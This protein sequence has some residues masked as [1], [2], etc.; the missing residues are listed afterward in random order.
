MGTDLHAYAYE[1]KGRK[2]TGLYLEEG[3]FAAMADNFEIQNGSGETTFSVNENGDLYGA[4]NAMFGGVVF[5]YKV[6]EKYLSESVNWE[7]ANVRIAFNKLRYEMNGSV[8]ILNGSDTDYNTGGAQTLLIPKPCEVINGLR[9][10]FV[11]PQAANV[12]IGC[13]G[14]TMSNGEVAESQHYSTEWLV[15]YDFKVN[16]STYSLDIGGL[17]YLSMVVGKRVINTIPYYFWYVV[18]YNKKYQA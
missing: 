17:T 7:V 16:A 9:L 12:K 18:A 11:N 1:Y 3:K 13:V 5:T 4:G 15:S 8:I 2:K 6:W 10:E 14:Y